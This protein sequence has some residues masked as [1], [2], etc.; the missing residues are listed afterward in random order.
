MAITLVSIHLLATIGLAGTILVGYLLGHASVSFEFHFV[1]ALLSTLLALFA[2]SMTMF[3]FIGTGKI[4]KDAAIER[5]FE[6]DLKVIARTRRMKAETS[7]IA[8][9]AMVAIIVS[10]VIGGGAVPRP[11]IAV[12]PWIHGGAAIVGLVLHLAAFRAELRNLIANNTLNNEVTLRAA[13]LGK[14][15]QAG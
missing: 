9:L 7:G 3:Y 10:F 6:P 5:G 12:S 11:N 8:T 14:P 1:L 2:H 13:R 15:V 4:L